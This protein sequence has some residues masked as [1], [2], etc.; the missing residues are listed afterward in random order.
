MCL[1]LRECFGMALRQTE[2]F[3]QSLLL[4]LDKTLKAPDDTTLSRR[5]DP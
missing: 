2:G 5:A 3:V 1:L 4:R